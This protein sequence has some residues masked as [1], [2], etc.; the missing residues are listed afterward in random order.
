MTTPQKYNDIHIYR[1]KEKIIFLNYKPF[2][3]PCIQIYHITNMDT[4]IFILFFNSLNFLE[5]SFYNNNRG[6]RGFPIVFSF[7][8]CYL[9]AFV[10]MIQGKA[11]DIHFLCLLYHVSTQS[12]KT[13]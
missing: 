7:I 13:D 2:K 3:Y 9:F 4:S 5:V 10:C 12:K 1:S 11:R 6:A 8:S